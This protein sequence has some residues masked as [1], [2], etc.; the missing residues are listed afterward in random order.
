MGVPGSVPQA[1]HRNQRKAASVERMSRIGDRDQ[2]RLS[3]RLP[4]RGIKKWDRSS[5]S[6]V[7]SAL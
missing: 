3:I 4:D 7:P 6:R 2:F 5:I 1:A